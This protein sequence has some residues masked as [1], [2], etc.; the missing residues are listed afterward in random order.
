[1]IILR[2][3][4][5]AQTAFRLVERSSA[6][7]AAQGWPVATV[8]TDPDGEVL[9]ALRMDG[10]G[11]HILGFATDKAHTAA[12]MRKTTKDYFEEMRQ[13]DDSRMVLANRNR[14]IV[15][16]GGLPVVHEGIVV[17]GIGVSGVKDFED[18]ECAEKALA[19]EGL[20][21]R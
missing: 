8:V 7:A 11:P 5:S 10:V 21:W 2:P 3:F 16:G 18:I 6:H 1:M 20:G 13:R 12:L 19:S 9:A 15:W 14:L 4:L 17:G